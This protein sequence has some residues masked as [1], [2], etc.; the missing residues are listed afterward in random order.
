M[1]TRRINDDSR[2]MQECLL[3]LS[4]PGD[5]QR[6]EHVPEPGPGTCEWVFESQNF[7]QWVGG[8]PQLLFIEG[9]PGCG[10]STL[11]KY[12]LERLGLLARHDDRIILSHFFDI[13]SRTSTLE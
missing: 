10:K 6:I 13:S 4:R 2:M 3:S 12:V 5:G 9:P 1:S 11:A 7:I 8:S